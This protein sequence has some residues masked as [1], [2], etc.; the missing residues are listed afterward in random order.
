MIRIKRL[1]K[2]FKYAFRGL[3]KAFKEE[4]NIR[5]Q[6]FIGL[7]VVVIGIFFNI[8]KFEW[9]MVFFSIGVVLLMELVNSAVERVADILRPRINQYVKEIKDIM[10]AAVM[11]ASIMSFLIGLFIF[12]PYF[13]S[14]FSIVF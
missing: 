9:L 13:S 8:S 5:I 14:F 10:S 7:L 4:Q 12:W 11:L 1:F 3:L 6:F 2:S